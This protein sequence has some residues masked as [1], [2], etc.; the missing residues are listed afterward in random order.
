MNYQTES[1][2]LEFKVLVQPLVNLVFILE[3]VPNRCA[4]FYESASVG[5]RAVIEV[6]HALEVSFL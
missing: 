1:R 5:N 2:P 3:D 4:W 6:R